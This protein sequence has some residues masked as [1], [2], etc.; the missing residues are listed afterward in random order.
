[1]SRNYSSISEPKTLTADVSS[2]A[3]QITLNNVTGLPSVPYV[4]V[5]NPDTANEEVILVTTDQDGVT[6][7]TVKVSRAIETGASAQTHTNGDTVKHMIVGSDLQLP[8]DHI[9]NTTT[10]HGVSGAVVG[11]T[12]TQTLTNKTLTSPKINENVALTATATELNVLD[13]ITASTAELNIMD[14]VTSTTAELNILDGVTSSTAELNILDGVT[15]SAAELNILDGA[16]LST[17]EL[18]YVDGVT[19]AVQTQ[20]DTIVNTTIPNATPVGTIVMFGGTDAPTGWLLCD[21]QSTASYAALAAV[22]GANVP[23]LRGRAPIG[24]GTG[25]GL[26]ARALGD[27]TGTE[28]HALTQAQ[29]PRHNHGINPPQV[30]GTQGG[31]GTNNYAPTG[32]NPLDN[33]TTF[34]TGG[35]GTAQSASNGVAHP[36]MQPSLAVNFIIKH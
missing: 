30:S 16:T 1:M 28:T 23:D 11:T 21:G 27:I 13:G 19:S 18:N 2:V 20:I 14:G 34:F 26:T 29:M 5:L 22:V 9:D 10:A 3:T 25:T 33:V 17:A 6:S 32:N 36:N 35:S 24:V 12:N 8:H 7:P 15:S 4:L 31:G